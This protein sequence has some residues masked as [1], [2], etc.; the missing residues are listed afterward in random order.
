MVC[1]CAA[2]WGYSV[3]DIYDGGCTAEVLRGVGLSPAQLKAA[4]CPVTEQINAG[5]SLLELKAGG[6]SAAEL[7]AFTEPSWQRRYNARDLLAVG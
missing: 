7:V 3:E 1:F 6:Y 5:Y 2:G 4:G